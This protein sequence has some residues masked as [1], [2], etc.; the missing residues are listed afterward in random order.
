MCVCVAV[1]ARIVYTCMGVFACICGGS[2]YACMFVCACVHI[3]GVFVYM[4]VLCA[5]MCVFMCGTPCP[6]RTTGLEH[7]AQCVYIHKAKALVLGGELRVSAARGPGAPRET[8]G[9]G[10]GPEGHAGQQ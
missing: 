2:V 1:C 10:V 9:E 4:S 5:C 6:Q 7:R 3:C 8:A